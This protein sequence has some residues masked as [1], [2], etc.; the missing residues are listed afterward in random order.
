MKEQQAVLDFFAQTENLPLGLAVAEQM[1]VLREK[2]N[3][4]FWLTLQ[5][6]L[7]IL[8][9][10]HKLP[11]QS[12]VIDDRNAAGSVVGLY[13]ALDPEQ[14]QYLRPM[15]EQQNIGGN[16]RI[17]FGLMWSLPPTP[18][19]LA[20]PAVQALKHALQKTGFNSNENHLGWQWTMLYP[21][22]QDFLLRYARHT[23]A[24]LED[25]L[26]LLKTLLLEQHDLIAAANHALHSAPRR[27][28]GSLNQLRDELINKR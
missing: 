2:M 16:L 23:E 4:Q 24:V 6:P 19:Q 28:A 9:A 7:D 20:F 1:D 27:L 18:E 11:W 21:R 13:C 3:S 22:R 17:F 10:E 25:A 14:E 8:I 26:A 15:L 12:T 5:K